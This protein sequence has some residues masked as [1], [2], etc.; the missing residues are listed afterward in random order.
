MPRRVSAEVVCGTGDRD[1]WLAARGSMITASDV[2]AVLGLNPYQSPL[3][4]YCEKLGL[5]PRGEIGEPGKW[6]LR[7]ERAIREAYTEETG[8]PAREAQVLLRSAEHP[9]LGATC[10][11]YTT[12][13]TDSDPLELKTTGAHRAADWDDGAPAYYMPQIQ[14]QIFVCGADVASAAVLIG[15]QRFRWFDVERDDAVI[16][17]I[18]ELTA[19]F[20]R[21]LALKEPPAPTGDES[22]MDALRALFPQEH[23]GKRIELPH[24]AQ[25]LDERIADL[26]AQVSVFEEERSRLKQELA[27]M[28][29]DAE[30]AYLP[31][32]AKW[33][34]RTTERKEYTVQAQTRRELRRSAAKK[35]RAK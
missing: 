11:A 30:E 15:G 35:G 29:G 28:I 23:E 12:I 7:L 19:D 27:A 26:G 34:W 25:L 21:R 13:R 5:L 22:S 9:H 2:A 3:A 18:I 17:D 6:G 31:N 8:R 20:Q 32:G 10:D 14:T 24:A 4:L 33:T 16:R 1:A